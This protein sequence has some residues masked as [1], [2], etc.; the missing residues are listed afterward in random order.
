MVNLYLTS[1]GDW[2]SKEWDEESYKSQ[3]L[4]VLK[5]VQ[6]GQTLLISDGEI[7]VVGTLAKIWQTVKG[8]FGFTNLTSVTRVNSEILKGL[9]YGVIRGWI[10][11][12]LTCL[13]ASKQHYQLNLS[14]ADFAR[15]AQDFSQ[16]K[17]L[18][19]QR[20][21]LNT[22]QATILSYHKKNRNALA[23]S[24]WNRLCE[25][26]EI[27][28]EKDPYFGDTWLAL[29]KKQE[30]NDLAFLYLYNA[31]DASNL[32]VPFQRRVG[33][34]FL[35]LLNKIKSSSLEK[36]E[37]S[38]V[39]KKIVLE[40]VRVGIDIN[41]D[42]KNL[43]DYLGKTLA[44]FADDEMENKLGEVYVLQKKYK[45]AKPYLTNL[46]RMYLKQN[47]LDEL[48]A[49]INIQ[50]KQLRDYSGL[51]NTSEFL[52]CG[53][54]QLI[55][56]TANGDEQAKY[57]FRKAMAYERKGRAYRQIDYI[58]DA[59]KEFDLAIKLL[60]QLSS[61][62]K[63][64]VEYKKSLVDIFLEKAQIHCEF[65]EYE[66]AIAAFAQA[67]SVCLAS[68]QI[69]AINQ[70]KAICFAEMGN[71]SLQND[72]KKSLE[73]YLKAI[74]LGLKDE[75]E[76]KVV[77]CHLN[78]IKNIYQGGFWSSGDKTIVFKCQQA[79]YLLNPD[80]FGEHIPY[81]IKAHLENNDFDQ[82]S[83]FY[84]EASKKWKNDLKL[85][86]E[87]YYLLGQ[88]SKKLALECYEKALALA[89]SNKEYNKSY[90]QTLLETEESKILRLHSPGIEELKKSI[91]V[92]ESKVSCVLDNKLQGS[93]RTVLSRLYKQLARKMLEPALLNYPL[94][95]ASPQELQQ[96]IARHMQTFIS[97]RLVFNQALKV[98]QNDAS[99]FF[100]RA[101]LLDFMGDDKPENDP[102]CADALR[103]YAE[104]CRLNS[105]NPYYHYRHIEKLGKMNNTK[106]AEQ[107][108]RKFFEGDKGW[109]FSQEP[110][111]YDGFSI[112]Y[113][114]WFDNR[115]VKGFHSNECVHGHAAQ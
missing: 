15:A 20:F 74:D 99:L 30:K 70:A 13:L 110:L 33:L 62:D 65:T 17:T 59:L 90:Y 97:V 58:D 52:I 72:P 80:T 84:I 88:K 47:K 103:D 14:I 113:L 54:D 12:D 50:E 98:C 100:E 114:N 106:E 31:L 101:E 25:T 23:P 75:R 21:A 81:L 71:E 107:K 43:D 63:M 44:L 76:K 89:S 78:D 46:S 27:T 51:Q 94:K 87:N 29:A 38:V 83:A 102:Y 82:A 91:E 40:L 41:K 60:Q 9:Y 92:L 86:K 18:E 35:E 109:L 39:I 66:E 115:F 45:N 96:H 2:Y 67:E 36:Q 68:A 19:D 24:F 105:K 53:L 34:A 85:S 8:F 108:K 10:P 111:N 32:E 61:Q 37:N 7:K 4:D 26:A 28:E 64:N 1:C 42:Y 48:E 79:L 77:A 6:S 57:C 73:C 104:S 22:M 93:Y 56:K 112:I 55:T 3:F 16:G 11:M 95:D 49:I 5:D 69:Q